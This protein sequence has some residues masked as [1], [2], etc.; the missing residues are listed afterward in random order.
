VVT[1]EPNPRSFRKISENV[2]LNGF[3]HVRIR[4]LALGS[5]PGCATLVFPADETARGSLESDIADQIRQEAQVVSVDVEVDT[6]DNQVARG[7]PNP[8]FVKLDVEGLER[9]VLEGM[10]GML[11]TRHPRLY[12]EMHGADDRRKL[13]NLTSVTAFLWRHAYD[14]LH[15][16][17]ETRLAAESDLP[18]ALHGHLY[19]T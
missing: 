10:T 19:C 13:E 2:R 1:F 16:E 6:L 7:L 8:D 14:V 5:K 15:V 18:V 11:T 3:S 17:S 9:D 4:Q 12:I